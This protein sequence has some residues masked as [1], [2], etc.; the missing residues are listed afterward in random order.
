MPTHAS[1]SPPSVVKL[2]QVAL[3]RRPK[4]IQTDFFTL[5]DMSKS[6]SSDL[7]KCNIVCSMLT[8]WE[9]NIISSAYRKILVQISIVLQPS[10]SDFNFVTMSSINMAKRQGDMAPPCLTPKTSLKRIRYVSAPFNA[11]TR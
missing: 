1:K 5:R 6:S 3:K 9:I 10:P 4:R 11:C 8:E 7:H 2:A